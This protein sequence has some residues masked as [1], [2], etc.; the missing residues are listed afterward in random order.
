MEAATTH[1]QAPRG[2]FLAGSYAADYEVSVDKS[3]AHSGQASGSIQSRRA[4][5][6][7]F[8]TLMQMCKADQYRGQRVRKSAYARAQAVSNWAERALLAAVPANME[9]A[10]GIV[11]VKLPDIETVSEI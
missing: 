3:I 4:R 6:R 7:G 11:D 9:V 5:P 2:W 1:S 8:G 10:A